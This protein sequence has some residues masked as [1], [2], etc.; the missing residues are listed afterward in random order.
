MIALCSW[1]IK[2]VNY[3]PQLLVFRTKVYYQDKSVQRRRIKG[4]AIVIS[5]HITV[6][7][8]AVMMFVFYSRT[9]RCLMAEL[10][11]RQ[12]FL[13]TFLL[14]ILGGIRVDR[15]SHDYSFV[16]KCCKILKKGG[17]IEIYPEARIPQPGEET[18]LPFKS[19]AAYIAL[20]S[21]A[22]IIPVYNEGKY[23]KLHRNKVI[24][25]T[26]IDV[27]ELYDNS[28]GHTE[29]LE[30]ISKILRQRVIELK[31]ELEEQTK[32]ENKK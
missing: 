28:M 14:K 9:L 27:R 10:M 24:I 4:G 19:S 29:N 2:I 22:P 7:D 30:N 5:N 20:E 17:V 31:D 32:A 8:F 13:L 25:G 1:I 23:F 11:F 12:N 6:M 26:P 16:S 3:I 15:N 18:P 21:G